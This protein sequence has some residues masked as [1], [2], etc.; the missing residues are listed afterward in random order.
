MGGLGNQIFQI[1]ATI[2]FSIK[3]QSSFRF[4]SV[5]TL[6]GGGESTLRYTFWNTFFSNLKPFLSKILPQMEVIKENT[7][8][9][10][11]IPN[12]NLSN[13][14]IMLHGYFQSY[15]Y[16]QKYYNTICNIIKLD[17]M[18]EQ[19]VIKYNIH[20]DYLKNIVSMHFR[21]G[22]YKKVSD[23]HPIMPYE[24]YK[25]SLLH[26]KNV[27]NNIKLNVLFFCENEDIETVMNTINNLQNDFP[28][29]TFERKFSFLEDWEQMLLMSMCSHN[30]IANSSFSWWG[31]YFNSNVDKIVC[32]PSLWF[33]E[34]ANI[35][36]TDLCPSEWTKI[37]V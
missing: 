6:G 19:I 31:A 3:S 35:D 25:N 8:V 17:K 21:L 5:D 4:L 28:N 29:Y 34:I 15:K 37:Q 13:K 1:F 10:K 20:E 14:N 32:Y 7:F 18:K 23:F 12:S 16:F 26:I 27:T 22:D 36:T 9:Y 24:Y 11:D 33:G 30:I 2:A